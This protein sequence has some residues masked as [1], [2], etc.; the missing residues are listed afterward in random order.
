MI[1]L[2]LCKEGENEAQYSGCGT[3]ANDPFDMSIPV[4]HHCEGNCDYCNN[5]SERLFSY[6]EKNLRYCILAETHTHTHT[7]THNF[8][9]LSYLAG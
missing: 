2:L 3:S 5:L 8:F 9:S 6:L 4:S 1:Q 7:H